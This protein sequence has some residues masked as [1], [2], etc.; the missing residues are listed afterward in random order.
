MAQA[1]GALNCS[2]RIQANCATHF[3]LAFTGQLL[4]ESL[5]SLTPLIS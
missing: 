2:F 4:A 5:G 1:Q 3:E